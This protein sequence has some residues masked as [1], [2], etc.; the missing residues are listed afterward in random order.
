[1][2]CLKRT[3]AL[4]LEVHSAMLTQLQ[5]DKA[6]QENRS[7][8]AVVNE[9]AENL[10]V[11][12]EVKACVVFYLALHTALELRNC[13]A[14]K[15]MKQSLMKQTSNAIKSF[16]SQPQRN[17]QVPRKQTNQTAQKHVMEET[18]TDHVSGERFHNHFRFPV[19]NTAKHI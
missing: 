7:D 5:G 4:S 12:M 6:Q 11:R 9:V 18:D 10:H 3:A 8:G 1:M 16:H 15:N 13:A 17:K 14:H 19:I 2:L